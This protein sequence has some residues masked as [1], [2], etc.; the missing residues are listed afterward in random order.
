MLK[1][2]VLGG[3]LI[4]TPFQG[5]IMLDYDRDGDGRSEERRVYIQV[6]Q[7]PI[8]AILRLE[9]VLKDLNKDGRYSEDE[10]VYKRG[11]KEL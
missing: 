11:D 6:G 1:E 8:S 2:I 7:T 5:G 10:I 9:M 4:A 3:I